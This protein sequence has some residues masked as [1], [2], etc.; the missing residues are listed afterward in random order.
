MLKFTSTPT[1][2]PAVAPMPTPAG[3]H[4]TN[5]GGNAWSLPDSTANAQPQDGVKHDPVV[6][7]RYIATMANQK[8][9]RVGGFSSVVLDPED[10]RLTGGT[11]SLMRRLLG[12]NLHKASPKAQGQLVSVKAA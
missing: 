6:Q 3:F 2:R 8:T 11:R 5:H 7:R 9:K 12:L 10:A 4:R 1:S